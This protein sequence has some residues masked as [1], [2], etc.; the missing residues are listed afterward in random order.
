MTAFI[1]ITYLSCGA[2]QAAYGYE[3]VFMQIYLNNKPNERGQSLVELAI[4]FT[5]ILLLLA[6]LTDLGRAFFT[7]LSLRDAAQE[8]AAYGSIAPADEGAIEDRI[9]NASNFISNLCEN[10]ELDIQINTPG[11]RCINYP[12]EVIITY[13]EFPIVVP[14]SSTFI[15]DQG[16]TLRARAIDTILSP[17]CP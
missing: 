5:F 13:A 10:N 3:E 6:G 17:S 7:F 2:D 12:V 11:L 9:C 15:G 16:I 14:F 1:S 8:G 4:S